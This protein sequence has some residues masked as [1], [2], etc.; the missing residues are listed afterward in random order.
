MRYRLL[1]AASVSAR[2]QIGISHGMAP[3]PGGLFNLMGLFVSQSKLH[4]KHTKIAAQN[5]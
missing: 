1:A 2:M 3:L 5:Q 4:A